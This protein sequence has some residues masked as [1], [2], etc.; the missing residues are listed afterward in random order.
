MT[1]KAATFPVLHMDRS[2]VAAMYIAVFFLALTLAGWYLAGEPGRQELENRFHTRAAE[3]SLRLES[4]LAGYEQILRG[5]T[6]LMSASNPVSRTEW[7]NYIAA[8]HLEE[9]YPGIQ[10]VGFA[11]RIAA[12][13][14]PAHAAATRAEGFPD[15][16]LWPVGLRNEY[17]AIVYLEPFIGR[18][19]RVLGYDM[20]SDPVRREAMAQAR[21]TGKTAI[22]RKVTL[23]QETDTDQQSGFLMYTGY[24]SLS[25]LKRF[26]IDRLK[27][28]KSFIRD[29]TTDR[30]DAA[31]TTAIIALAH[32]LG[33]KV[34]AEGVETAEQRDFLINAG[35]D[36]AQGF[37][38]AKP[39][40]A[41]EFQ[42]IT[43]TRQLHVS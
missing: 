40:D 28:D 22:T 18:N 36:Q 23:L 1:G 7:R 24:S 37:F 10:G 39:V 3:V 2:R 30:D 5:G 12:E 43:S 6:G 29:I 21:D 4:R 16:K 27:I 34:V 15:Y 32:N 26:P 9:R 14:L 25:Y 11:K 13:E 20:Y 42:R 35:C 19:T 31:M 33:L 41:A 17:T 38:Y 8:L